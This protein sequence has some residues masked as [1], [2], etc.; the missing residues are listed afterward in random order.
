[1]A[2]LVR[3]GVA[4]LVAGPVGEGDVADPH[5]DALVEGSGH[6]QGAAV[7]QA[8][9][10]GHLPAPD[11]ALQVL[12]RGDLDELARD[13]GFRREPV[14]LPRVLPP[15]LRIERSGHVEGEDQRVHSTGPQA[16]E[17]DVP[18]GEPLREVRRLLPEPGGNVGVTVDDEGFVVQVHG[19]ELI[20]ERQLP[21]S[22]PLFS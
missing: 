10:D 14:E 19:W 8:E 3:R 15:P 6:G 20:L 4:P 21:V 16:G 12:R 7:L 17:V 2:G 9:E 11:G 22:P 13:E 5:A 1:M 18:V